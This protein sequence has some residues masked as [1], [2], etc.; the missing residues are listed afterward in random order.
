M[1]AVGDS[2]VYTFTAPLSF[3]D[4]GSVFECV[5]VNM[6]GGEGRKN[7]TLIVRGENW[8]KLLHTVVTS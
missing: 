2:V 1:T 4:N 7:F 3:S 6:E 8:E 5:A